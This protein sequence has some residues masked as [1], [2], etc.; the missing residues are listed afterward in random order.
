MAGSVRSLWS[1]QIRPNILSP[2]AILQ[3]QADELTKIT[4]GT[5]IGDVKQRGPDSNNRV[6]LSLDMIVPALNEY[7]HRVLVAMHDSVMPYPVMLDAEVFRPIGLKA[8]QAAVRLAPL[9]GS[10]EEKPANRAD[11]DKELI[12][13]V[14]KTLKSPQVVSI[15]QSLIARANE[16]MAERERQAQ[17]DSSSGRGD[18]AA[19]PSTAPEPPVD[20]R[21]GDRTTSDR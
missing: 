11:S 1:D 7:R 14:E 15:A 20:Q 5:L 16:V 19:S 9:L 18:P 6:L 2:W 3:V 12:E 17:S 10:E 13:L 4:T 8:I 21:P